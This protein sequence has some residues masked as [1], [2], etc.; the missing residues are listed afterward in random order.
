MLFL[1][2]GLMNVHDANDAAKEK[3]RTKILGNDYQGGAIHTPM[4]QGG[5]FLD[6]YRRKD[7]RRLSA[8]RPAR[9]LSCYE[10]L[11]NAIDSRFNQNAKG[12]LP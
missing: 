6:V 11:F 3:S 2:T 5:A 10:A 4:M 8:S 9:L 12:L 7:A 1:P